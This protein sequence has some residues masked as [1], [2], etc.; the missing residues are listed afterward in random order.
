[1]GSQQHPPIRRAGTGGT[2]TSAREPSASHTEDPGEDEREAARLQ[3]KL[4]RQVDE[5]SMES[6]PASDPPATTTT[7][8]GGKR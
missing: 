6:F 3:E 7:G 8:V 2:G 1:M 4:D 5:A